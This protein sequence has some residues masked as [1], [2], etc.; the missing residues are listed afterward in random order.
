MF[1]L[2]RTQTIYY[3][4]GNTQQIVN[5][6]TW[7]QHLLAIRHI[8]SPHDR[9]LTH[10]LCSI[11]QLLT[12]PNLDRSTPTSCQGPYLE[13]PPSHR[14]TGWAPSSEVWCL[15]AFL[16][17]AIFSGI[18]VDLHM[19]LWLR[20]FIPYLDSN[21]HRLS[22]KTSYMW[23]TIH[24]GNI[25]SKGFPDQSGDHG[26]GVHLHMYYINGCSLYPCQYVQHWVCL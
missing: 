21:I 14:G 18:G 9:K 12:L 15:S 4:Q 10:G 24:F 3:V 22:S 17:L 25:W 1:L 20:K 13:G 6:P 26:E 8:S 5:P 23:S 16:S 2:L 19:S 11:D 7:F